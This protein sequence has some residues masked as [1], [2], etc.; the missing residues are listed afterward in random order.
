MEKIIN[1][2]F[3]KSAL[4]LASILILS[5]GIRLLGSNHG[6]PDIN[7]FFWETDEAATVNIS[8]G[9]GSGDLNPH[10][11]NKPAALYYITFLFYGV[12]YMLGKIFGFFESTI[13]FAIYY[14]NNTYYFYI[15]ARFIVIIF[16]ILT[17]YVTYMIGKKAYGNKAGLLAAL[18]LSVT[19]LHI[20]YSRSALPDVPS[21]FFLT[22]AMYQIVLITL[23]NKTNN[24]LFAGLFSGL[25]ASTKYHAGFVWFSIP[26]IIILDL[27][28]KKSVNWRG[29]L[30]SFFF[31]IFGF[32]VVTPYAILDFPTFI[33]SLKVLLI[34]KTGESHYA[35]NW[36]L[37]HI[38][39]FWHMTDL[40]PVFTL[41]SFGA[42]GYAIYKHTKSDL[43]C[44]FI[45]LIFYTFFSLPS[46]QWA[47]SHYLLPIIPF[48]CILNARFMA[49][50]A[51]KRRLLGFFLFI[52]IFPI[53]YSEFKN[54]VTISKYDTK[55]YAKKWIEDH[56]PNATNILMTGLYDPQLSITNTTLQRLTKHN[57]KSILLPSRAETLRMD[58]G[59]REV[60]RDLKIKNL[61]QSIP[62]YNVYLINDQEFLS[63]NY[64]NLKQYIDSLCIEYIIITQKGMEA[65]QSSIYRERQQTIKSFKDFL[66]LHANE[67]QEFTPVAW[68]IPGSKITIYKIK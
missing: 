10:S 38:R 1:I 45:I 61:T 47:P 43:V 35:P 32:I 23:E 4:M 68:K 67:I 28:L 55:Y 50:W 34:A 42:I 2:N 59:L 20:V 3:S 27:F 63:K 8:M 46:I 14:L 37:E 24:Y 18:L 13:Q 7:R 40:G 5:F 9:M 15:I 52:L 26:A 62:A 44:L 17:V 58:K 31:L 25:A 11:F 19:P 64:S 49:S 21:V 54:G 41:L 36:W 16:G 51:H 56:F 29:F 6:L 65:L 39:Q 30:Y 60:L 33:A 12:F 66:H 53:I 48:L 22:L 57:Y